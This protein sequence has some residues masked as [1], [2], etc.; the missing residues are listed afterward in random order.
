M[1]AFVHMPR[2]GGITASQHLLKCGLIKQQKNQR[3]A[4]SLTEGE[5]LGRVIGCYREPLR[6]YPSVYNMSRIE[7]REGLT[8]QEWLPTFLEKPDECR[9]CVWGRAPRP[10]CPPNIGAFAYYH[11]LYF[12][13]QPDKVL[14]EFDRIMHLEAGGSAAIAEHLLDWA[15]KVYSEHL[16]VN[17]WLRTSCLTEDLKQLTGKA[18]DK[19]R[20]HTI[21]Y[22]TFR[23]TE[24]Y[25]NDQIDQ[26]KSM[27]GLIIYMYP[28]WCG[29]SVL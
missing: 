4:Y 29:G 25:T 2:T 13:D 16:L 19:I 6:W 8:F 18:P 20:N 3:P 28:E 21:D 17:Y 26:V 22:D 24:W 14:D 23:A 10:K 1:D 11:V 7:P 9:T 5:R 12:C 15:R 27:D